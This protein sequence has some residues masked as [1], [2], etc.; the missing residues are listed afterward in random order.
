MTGSDAKAVMNRLANIAA[1]MGIPI[2]TNTPKAK[3]NSVSSTARQIATLFFDSIT[4]VVPFGKCVTSPSD[5]AGV[6]PDGRVDQ[7][8]V[9]GDQRTKQRP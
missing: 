3:T 4:M 2:R 6:R 7:K 8:L 5:G 9:L 1:R